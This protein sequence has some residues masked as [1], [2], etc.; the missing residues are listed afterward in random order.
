MPCRLLPRDRLPSESGVPIA[1]HSD[2]K[3]RFSRR[4][5][6]PHRGRRG[7]CFSA[8]VGWAAV[9]K[10]AARRSEDV[11]RMVCGHRFCT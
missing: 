3:A 5:M 11:V 4:W 9:P 6:R 8:A 1:V 2:G 10:A 7:T